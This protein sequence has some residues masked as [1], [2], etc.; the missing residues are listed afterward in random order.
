MR[1]EEGWNV[2]ALKAPALL[3]K[4]NYI[5]HRRPP[6]SDKQLQ[7][8]TE[9]VADIGRAPVRRTLP[10]RRAQTT[11]KIRISGIARPM[12][13]WRPE[14]QRAERRVR[15]SQCSERATTSGGSGRSRRV[16]F[17]PSPETAHAHEMDDRQPISQIDTLPPN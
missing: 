16:T 6:M 1:L 15:A 3:K 17:F 2:L 10:A 5:I 9:G 4:I 11:Q 8:V 14:N 12:S 7:R 13:T